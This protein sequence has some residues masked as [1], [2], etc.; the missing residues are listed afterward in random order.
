MFSKAARKTLGLKHYKTSPF[1]N[2]S[3]KKPWF[4]GDCRTARRKFHLPKRMNY[5][6]N[7]T[8]SKTILKIFSKTYKNQ[9]LYVLKTTKQN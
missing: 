9:C 7:S 3:N 2:E 4:N 5:R 6:Y 1:S 8:E